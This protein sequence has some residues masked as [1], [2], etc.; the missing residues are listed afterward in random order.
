M[1]AFFFV[2]NVGGWHTGQALASNYPL[3]RAATTACLSAIIVMQIVNVFICRSET[4]SA[5]S[6]G[7]SSNK[8]ILLGL[9]IEIALVITIGYTSW[10][11]AIFGTAPIPL[12]AWLFVVPFALAMLVLEELRKRA[13]RLRSTAANSF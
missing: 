8:L 2:L 5:F 12:T 6:F 1:A 11:N 7:L 4:R 9:T 3:Y 13:V 10:G